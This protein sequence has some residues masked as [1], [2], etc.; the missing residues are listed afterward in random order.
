[1]LN[2]QFFEP[3]LLSYVGSAFGR[4]RKAELEST[5]R[6]VANM[7]RNRVGTDTTT[8]TTTPP[9]TPPPQTPPRPRRNPSGYLPPNG[10]NGRMRQNQLT[11]VG[12]L[13]GSPTGGP[14][15]YGNSAYLEHTAAKYFIKAKE[16]ARKEGITL[17]I[18]SAYRSYEHQQALVGLY[19]VVA[20][21]GTSA[22]GLGIALDIEVDAG[23]YWLKDNGPKYGW[24][25]SQIPNDDVHFEFMGA[26]QLI[27]KTRSTT[28]LNNI[29][30]AKVLSTN[31]SYEVESNNIL[32]RQTFI[33]PVVG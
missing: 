7:V 11:K 28:N 29:A 2:G 3:V 23:W 13:S 19:P 15:W 6:I 14:Y 32:M 18:N 25:W 30:S 8:T 26:P 21:P 17:T 22:H 1:L 24:E 20:A 5:G 10:T 4:T 27:S 9:Q 31:T 12:M 16:A 33:Q